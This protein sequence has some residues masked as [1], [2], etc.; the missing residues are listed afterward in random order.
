MKLFQLESFRFTFAS[1][2]VQCPI[3]SIQ[4]P[5]WVARTLLNLRFLQPQQ[6]LVELEWFPLPKVGESC[7]L[8][9]ASCAHPLRFSNPSHIRSVG[10]P[11]KTTVHQYPEVLDQLERLAL[12]S[13]D[14]ES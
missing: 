12:A 1:R 13:L 5:L 8:L 9:Q 4:A 6:R 2:N 14:L 11:C 7:D 3:K 10:S